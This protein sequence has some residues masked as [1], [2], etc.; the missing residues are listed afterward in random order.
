VILVAEDDAD[1]RRLTRTVLENFNYTVIE[2]VDGEDAVRQ[3][4][5]NQD[6]IQLLLMDVIMPR[7]NGKEACEE[8]RKIRPDVKVIFTSGYP[9]EVIRQKGM[10]DETDL[11]L[12]KPASPR[13]T[14]HMVQDALY[15]D[16]C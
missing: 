13:E 7:K 9:A 4:A 5:S 6:T 8:I 1:V 10:L 12:F 3:F 2:A 16:P 15:P 14:L 11:F